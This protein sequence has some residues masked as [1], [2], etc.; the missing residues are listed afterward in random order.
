MDTARRLDKFYTKPAIARRLV[1]TLDL[2][3]YETIVEPSCGAGAFVAA[4]KEKLLSGSG[5][6]SQPALHFIDVASAEPAHRADFFDWTPPP[7]AAGGG[8]KCLVVGN[9]P[10]GKN[11]S[12]AVR[13]FNRAALFADTVAFIVPRTFQKRSTHNKLD[14][15][16]HLQ[17]EEVLEVDAFTFCG[18]PYAVPC[19]WQVWAKRG[20]R[21]RAKH[22]A[23]A[24]H[25][26]AFVN[27]GGGGDFAMRRVGV[28]AGRLF[29]AGV[30][31]RS[32]GSHLFLKCASPGRKPRVKERL[33]RLGLERCAVK[34]MTAGC[35]SISKSELCEMY[36]AASSL[37]G[38]GGGGSGGRAN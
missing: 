22:V 16:F 11:A 2:G 21:K 36:A 32:V 23:P 31:T 10:F 17:R 38:G 28:N 14:L 3:E 13:F 1:T 4:L 37:D 20:G 33:L 19:V 12:L 29:E 7:P 9:P 27:Q 34:F 24:V 35:P 25:D 8:G 18:E 15:R 30:A 6:R 26:F 5:E